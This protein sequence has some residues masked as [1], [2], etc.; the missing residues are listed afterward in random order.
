MIQL[1][2]SIVPT[3]VLLLLVSETL[4]LLFCYLLAAAFVIDVAPEFFLFDELGLFRICIV[5]ASILI[6]LYLEDLY[7]RIRITSRVLLAQQIL[8]V[9]GIAFLIQALLTYINRS[10]MLP[11]YLMIYGSAMA[12]VALPAWRML[13]AKF[14]VSTVG[15]QQVLLVGTSS[16][17]QELA[18]QLL[19]R[20]EFGHHILGYVGQEEFPGQTVPRLARLGELNQLKSLVAEHKPDKIIIGMSERRSRMPVQELLD[21]RLSGIYVEE[22][23]TAYEQAFGR[24]CTRELRPSQLIF[25]TAL[26]PSAR[27]EGMHTA[28]SMVIAVIG[29][30]LTAPIMLIVAILVRVT[31]SGPI[32]HR[33]IRSGLLGK[34]FT[35]YKFRS[36][37]ADAEVKTGAVWAQKNDPRITSIGK[38]LRTFRLDELPQFFN[39]LKGEMSMVGPRPERPEFVRT[40]SEKIPFY[41]QRLS[42]KPGLTGWAQINHKY[43][44]TIEDTITKLEYDLY[45]IKHISVTLDVYILLNTAKTVLL[46]RGAQ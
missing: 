40:L 2:R 30:L 20:P 46:G 13:Y 7:T 32:F 45:Y 18:G 1:I 38:Y 14:A 44:D 33:Q 21:M 43:G 19:S 17:L 10:L 11:R 27:T 31:S 16:V 12:F 39:V 25:S 9:L 15:T 4:V 42:V 6:G 23:A 24:V 37:R 28:L 8:M 34:E 41:S 29:T 3:S 22:A 35:V 5:V 26:G 36:M